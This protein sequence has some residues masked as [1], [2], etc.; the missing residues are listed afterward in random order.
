[1]QPRDRWHRPTRSGGRALSRSHHDLERSPNRCSRSRAKRVRRRSTSETGRSRKA[2][3]DRIAT[4]CRERTGR[5]R[6]SAPNT[7]RSRRLRLPSSLSMSWSIGSSPTARRQNAKLNRSRSKGTYHGGK[8]GSAAMRPQM[9]S[10]NCLA[11][12]RS[13]A[14][15]RDSLVLHYPPNGDRR[16]A[17]KQ[18]RVLLLFCGRDIHPRKCPGIE[19]GR[20][21]Q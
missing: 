21:R 14:I 10:T 15:F 13:R 16:S 3:Q 20:P 7:L 19:R 8:S 12:P 5:Q 9:V 2:S 6:C 1:M 4:R 17:S 18:I 11:R